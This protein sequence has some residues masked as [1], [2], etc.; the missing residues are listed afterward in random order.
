MTALVKNRLSRISLAFAH[1]HGAR[2][3]TSISSVERQMSHRRIRRDSAHSAR[4][5]GGAKAAAAKR[6]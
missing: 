6:A 5:N 1:A 3:R 4:R 2:L